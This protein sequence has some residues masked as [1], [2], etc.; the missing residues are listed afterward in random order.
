MKY[1][2]HKLVIH[3]LIKNNEE[4]HKSSLEVSLYIM[5]QKYINIKRDN[6]DKLK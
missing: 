4:I 1:L 2:C 3:Q 5:L 6:S